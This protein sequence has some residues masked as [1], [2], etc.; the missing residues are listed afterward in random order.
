MAWRSGVVN[1]VRVDQSR[2]VVARGLEP[3]LGHKHSGH[4]L[5]TSLI[6]TL[7]R[8]FVTS[9]GVYMEISFR[10]NKTDL[11]QSDS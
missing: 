5:V 4:S 2:C 9:A 7:T 11:T 1:H 8:Q 3:F 10:T 6:A